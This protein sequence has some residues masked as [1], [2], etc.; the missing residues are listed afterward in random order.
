V[1]K[2]KGPEARSSLFLGDCCHRYGMARNITI[3]CEQQSSCLVC[4][5][6]STLRTL[7]ISSV[8]VSTL[9]READE[10]GS[11]IHGLFGDALYSG[12]RSTRNCPAGLLP[13]GL[14]R[15]H[16]GRRGC[17]HR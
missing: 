8:V 6:L 17:F 7:L 5:F 4:H 14:F 12:R 16:M 10:E 13:N 3:I 15:R 1:V 9:Q 2:H 11:A